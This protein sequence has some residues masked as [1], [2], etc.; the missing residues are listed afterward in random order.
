MRGYLKLIFGL[1][2]FFALI[3]E[4]LGIGSGRTISYYLIL[5][6][7]FF[8]FISSILTN[9]GARI[10]FP[11]KF[12]LLWMIF[13]ILSV[14]SSVFSVNLQN[15]FEDMLFYLATF[16]IF[17]FVYNNKE[18][19]KAVILKIVFAVAV[20]FSLFSMFAGSIAQQTTL[21]FIPVDLKT[22]FFQFVYTAWSHNHLGDFLLL[23]ILALIFW[24]FVKKFN[25]AYLFLLIFFIP[26]F[27]FAYSRSAYLDLII[28]ILFNLYY[29][30]KKRGIR[31]K[32]HKWLVLLST[33]IVIILSVFIIAVPADNS[34]PGLI[35]TLNIS[36]KQNY[37]L[38]Q[39]YFFANRNIYLREGLLSIVAKP[40]FGVG[41]G[42]FIYASEEY[43]DVPTHYSV[44]AHNLFI[45]IFVENGCLAGIFFLLLFLQV[46]NSIRSQLD[47]NHV[48]AKIPEAPFIYILFFI[49][50]FLNF[51]TDFTYLIHSFFLLFFVLMGFV[52]HED[53]NIQLKFIPLVLSILL[54]IVF[55]MLIFSNLAFSKTDYELAVKLYPLNTEVYPYLI[56]S[57]LKQ[58]DLKSALSYLNDYLKYSGSDS[59]TLTFAGNVFYEYVG[60]KQA[61]K[62]YEKSYGANKFIDTR[63]VKNIY[64]L[65][66]RFEGTGSANNFADNYFQSIS[67][68]SNNMN[69]DTADSLHLLYLY[70]IN[71][72]D[73][74]N[75][76]YKGNCPYLL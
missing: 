8:L 46:F 24:L 57:K 28:V 43:T 42:N 51:Q 52:Y 74:C 54:V 44:T 19:L 59:N 40:L 16:L 7:P 50:I 68:M 76:I 4:G 17:I 11:Q 66:S 6:L 14:V 22:N 45:D 34:K 2:L 47:I 25:F 31:F 30:L 69:D 10:V 63:I 61:L 73:F 64:I 33:S 48:E 72:L 37:N 23:P 58:G 75:E 56:N 9:T 65:K 12:S 70:R 13:F 20:I 18:I 29:L 67:R 53:T 3:I 55:N 26:Y 21:L 60:A 71:A 36:L 27:I 39:K 62:Y 38:G 15:S 5:I 49:G 35:E 1:F 32:N 41:P